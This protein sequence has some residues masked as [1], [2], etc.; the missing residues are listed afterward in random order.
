MLASWRQARSAASSG[1][2]VIMA[3]PSRTALFISHANPED[4]T[5]VLWLGAK[6]SAL[7]Y[8]VWA[9]VFRLKPG[10]DWQRKLEYA[11]RN[12]SLKVLVV[13]TAL[14]VQKQGV[15]NEIQIATD[16]GKSVGDESF[17]IPLRLEPYDP[18]LLIAHAQHIDFES[19][20]SDG[21]NEL[22]KAL[23]DGGVPR[24][25]HSSSL[26]NQLQEIHA[27]RLAIKTE[28]LISNWLK[29]VRLPTH[30]WFHDYPPLSESTLSV[31]S[32][33]PAVRFRD[34][35]LTFAS[36]AT[37]H[38]ALP[39]PMRSLKY[40]TRQLIS[41]GWPDEGLRWYDATNIFSD[42]AHQSLERLLTQKQL[43]PHLL[44]AKRRA[45]WA[46]D[47][48][49]PAE[50][51]KFQWGDI[52]GSRQIRGY[53]EKRRV[54]WHIAPSFAVRTN[55]IPHV[56]VKTHLLFGED[57][58]S[59]LADNDRMHTL[60]RSFASGWR[61]PRWRDMT[62]AVLYWLTSGQPVWRIPAGGNQS[63]EIEAPPMQ[64]MSPVGVPHESDSE[65]D[66]DD[67]GIAD[68]WYDEDYSRPTE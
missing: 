17:I 66:E 35:F 33:V 37:Q 45:W 42:L 31:G 51:V 58:T 5:F 39:S 49:T 68:D 19:S 9:D 28:R 25:Q 34:G 38:L 3:A 57:L 61:N 44:S 62:L 7:G 48:I 16:V 43:H 29:I 54:Y 11:L 4:N 10:Q 12:R 21:L 15:R 8:E 60:R 6:L 46:P 47:E 63:F 20:W 32:T 53:S 41:E 26:W 2:S 24:S 67:P 1:F 14:G 36:N 40:S 55:P 30:I 13:G 59:L 65:T 52:R 56:R 23:I 22:L 64:F 27:K 50:K 18:P